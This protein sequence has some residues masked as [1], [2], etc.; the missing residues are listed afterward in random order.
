MKSKLAGITC[1][2]VMSES[3]AQA[4]NVE[5]SEGRRGTADLKLHLKPPLNSH[6]KWAIT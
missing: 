5:R 2:F 6:K 3:E 1:A 4:T